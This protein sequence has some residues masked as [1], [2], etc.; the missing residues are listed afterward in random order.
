MALYQW[1]HPLL[2][3]NVSV[4]F[5]LDGFATRDFFFFIFW[6]PFFSAISLVVHFRP[7]WYLR[8]QSAI[9][10]LGVVVQPLVRCIASHDFL[11]KGSYGECVATEYPTWA[12]IIGV[13]GGISLQHLAGHQPS[14]S[15]SLLLSS[16]GLSDAKVYEP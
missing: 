5:L 10:L 9:F 8:A 11:E 1:W 16:L 13:F 7:G 4:T 15:S 6:T 2:L 14:S 3:L 12:P